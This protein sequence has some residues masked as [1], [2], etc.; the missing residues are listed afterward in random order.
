MKL[1]YTQAKKAR[2]LCIRE[3]GFWNDPVWLRRLRGQYGADSREFDAKHPKIERMVDGL[4]ARIE[5]QRKTIP[6]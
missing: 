3:P 1:K 6:Q 2:R 4:R 5:T